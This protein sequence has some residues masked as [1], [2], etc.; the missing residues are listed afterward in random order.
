MVGRDGRPRRLW[1]NGWGGKWRLSQ[2]EG[3][4]VWAG[5]SAG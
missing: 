5:R 2:D 3:G 1:V 4:G